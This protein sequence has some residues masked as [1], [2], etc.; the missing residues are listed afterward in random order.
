MNAFELYDAVFDSANDGSDDVTAANVIAYAD[1]ALDLTISNEVAERVAK[2]RKEWL[3][4]VEA[5]TATA[6]EHYHLVEKELSEVE[7]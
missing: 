4:M 6:N 1:G 3:A 2:L 5:G 7:L